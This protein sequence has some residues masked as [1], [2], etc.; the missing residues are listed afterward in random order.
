MAMKRKNDI[1]Q[2][3]KQTEKQYIILR[4]RLAMATSRYDVI[5]SL[6]EELKTINTIK[7]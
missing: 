6:A 4:L 5:P 3:A 1:H 7:W 2:T